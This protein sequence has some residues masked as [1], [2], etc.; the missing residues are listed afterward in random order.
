MVLDLRSFALGCYFLDFLSVELSCSDNFWTESASSSLSCW[1]PC[2]F[3][4]TPSLLSMEANS[5]VR[6]SCMWVDL[7]LLRRVM[8]I[9]RQMTIANK[10]IKVRVEIRL[11]ITTVLS[12]LDF[13]GMSSSLKDWEDKMSPVGWGNCC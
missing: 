6:S 7:S 5:L 11:I 12:A 10:A 9:R 3:S 2:G 4:M 8:L 13:P 1:L